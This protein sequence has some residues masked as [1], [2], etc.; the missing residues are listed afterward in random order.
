MVKTGVM[1]LFEAHK[2]DALVYPTRPSRP[3]RIIP[4]E[5][6]TG[7]GA[8]PP[9]GVPLGVGLTDIGNITGFPDLVAPAG[10]TSDGLPVS[11]SFFGPA[12]SEAR[13]I[14]IAYAYEQALPPL[15]LA[16]STPALPGESFDY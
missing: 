2:L 11:I 6:L 15:P 9:G 16:P 5:P 14:E 13:L 4:D 8:P 3:H 1:G 7:R 10:L 12:F